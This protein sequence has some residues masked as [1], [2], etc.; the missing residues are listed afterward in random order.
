MCTKKQVLFAVGIAAS[1]AGALPARGVEVQ[2][3]ER[4]ISTNADGAKSV[5]ATDMDA[6]GDTDVLSASDFDKKIAWY[7]SDGGSPPTFTERVISTTA[8]T[9]WAVYATDVDGDGDIDVLSASAFDDKIAWYESDGGSP[10]TFTERVISTAADA[11]V[12]VF[13]TDLDGDGDTDVLSASLGDDKIA[14]YESDGGSPPTFTERVIS[15]GADWAV[16]VFATDVDGDGNIDVLSAS[17]LDDKIAW[18]ESDPGAPGPPSFTERVITTTPDVAHSV[19]ATDLDGD[20]DTDVLSA[21]QGTDK[22]AWYES[23]GGSP[24][25]FTERVISTVANGAV[26]V[27]ATDVDGDGD[28]DVLSAS[29]NDNKIA[30]YES[31]GGSPPSFTEQVISTAAAAATSVFATDL[32]GDGDTDVLSASFIDDKIAWYENITPICGNGTVEEGEECDDG[33]N[34][35]GDACSPK[36][37]DQNPQPDFLVDQLSIGRF[38]QTMIDLSTIPWFPGETT[39]SRHWS[40]FGNLMAVDYIKTKL[41]SYGYTNVT[42]DPYLYDGQARKSI[43]ATKMGTV[44]PTQMYIVSGHMDSN[45]LADVTNAPGFDDDGSGTALVLELAR[46]FA[47]TRTDISVRFILWNNEETGLDGSTAYAT[48]HLALQGTLTEPTWLGVIQHDM[49]LFDRFPVPDADVEYQT[50]YDFGGQAI[51]LA[52]FVCGAMARY[53]SMPCEVGDNMDFTDSVSFQEHTAS[54]S[55][56]ENQRVAEIGEESNPHWHKPTDR[57]DTFTQADIQFGF[58]IVKMTAGA[59]AELVNAEPDCDMNDIGDADDIAGGAP[60]TNADGVPDVCQDCNGNGTLDPVEIA[61]GAADCNT[62]G[63]PDE[64]EIAAGNADANGDGIPDECQMPQPPGLPL[65]AEHQVPKHRYVSIDSSTNG[66][67]AVALRMDLV[68]MDR[69]SNMPSRACTV[70]D[71]CETAIPG[72]GSCVQHEDVGTAGPWWVQAPQ[73]EPAGCL[74]DNVCGDDDWFARLGATPYYDTWT[75]G[76]LHLGDCEVLPVAT[77]E[78]RA[79]L[80]PNGIVCG[81]P[82]TIGTI[83]QPF[84]SPGFRGNYGDAVGPVDAITEQFTPPDGFTNV[85]DVSAWILTKQNYGTGN[86]PQTHPTWVDLHGQGDGNPPQ[87]PP[88]NG[89]PPNYIINVSDLGQIKKAFAGDTWTN[90]PGN[91]TPGQCP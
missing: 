31:D 63:V 36:C 34:D 54:I 2:F 39:P 70:Y 21:S 68:S 8:D 32:D 45:N 47:K 69:C 46:V 49:I 9:P 59:V 18:Y 12:S 5:F 10:P 65:A 74:P 81:D 6:D 24:P 38:R 41:E 20:G 64:C 40:T 62:N 90:D 4:V 77:Y 14:W 28:T 25:S 1:L 72:S 75:L 84:V 3:T 66:G 44:E 7:E 76:T 80:A 88:P 27:F 89:N 61:G 60:D 51:A 48:D 11:A 78:I 55:V 73:Q 17:G 83:E 82:L 87:P 35:F 50:K 71:D 19:F 91:M 43:Y 57:L 42:L 37:R 79:C 52:N 29:M 58:N 22:I 53:G 33:N 13:A 30:W 56:R 16:S 86:K 15:T 85:V 26:S 67:A 23:D